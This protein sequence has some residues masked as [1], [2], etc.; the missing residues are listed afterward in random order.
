MSDHD[1]YTAY[2]EEDDGEQEWSA[3]RI[4]KETNEAVR[5]E[6]RLTDE[7]YR[8]LAEFEADWFERE[9]RIRRLGAATWR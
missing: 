6:R 3:E 8:Q 5:E 1:Y 9:E 4:V 7:F 2:A